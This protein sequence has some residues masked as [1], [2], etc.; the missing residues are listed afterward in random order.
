M[1]WCDARAL[2][3][4]PRFTHARYR[5]SRKLWPIVAS[6]M[7]SRPYCIRVVANAWDHLIGLAFNEASASNARNRLWPALAKRFAAKLNQLG[8]SAYRVRF[9]LELQGPNRL[10]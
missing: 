3:R 5:Y 6:L 2:A 4:A 10:R 9:G 8:I 7:M 1:A